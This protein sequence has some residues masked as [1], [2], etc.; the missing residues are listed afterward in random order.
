MMKKSES[1]YLLPFFKKYK[2]FF[3]KLSWGWE[4][5]TKNGFS[6]SV[7]NTQKKRQIYWKSFL[8]PCPLHKKNH[9]PLPCHFL[10]F[11]DASR[12]QKLNEK[13]FVSLQNKAT[14]TSTKNIAQDCLDIRM[15]VLLDGSFW[16]SLE[17]ALF[18]RVKLKKDSFGTFFT[19]LKTSSFPSSLQNYNGQGRGWRRTMEEKKKIKRLWQNMQPSVLYISNPNVY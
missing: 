1:I 8:C 12:C 13:V 11:Q 9:S 14:A 17:S 7:L 19:L 16:I 2:E 10:L 6:W 18:C 3:T 4:Y 5:K 15:C